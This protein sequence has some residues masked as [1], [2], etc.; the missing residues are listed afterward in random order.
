VIESEEIMSEEASYR[1]AIRG[2][3]VVYI[4]M[5]LKGPAWVGESTPE[6]QQ[7]QVAHLANNRRLVEL[8][9]LVL[10]G[11]CLDGG[12]LRG[13]SVYRVDSPAEAQA[14]AESDPAVQAGHLAYEIHPWMVPAGILG[15]ATEEVLA[16]IDRAIEM[17]R[18]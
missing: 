11:P 9:K 6:T 5:L 15:E 14:L 8:G 18:E 1:P 10:V 3:T 7:L 16:S 2:M 4:E 17:S 12:H 13:V